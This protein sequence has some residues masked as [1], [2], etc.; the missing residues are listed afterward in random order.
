MKKRI[1]GAIALVGLVGAS[2][3]SCDSGKVVGGFDVP[4]TFDTDAKITVTFW[5][6]MGDNLQ[7]V[8]KEAIAGFN[9]YYPNVT[10]ESTQIGSY[11]DVKSQVVTEMSTG[12]FPSMA[13]CYDDHVAA[14][15][16]AEITVPLNNLMSNAKYGFGGSEV[17]YAIK[18]SDIVEGF[19]TKT[20]TF[21]DGNI[22]TVPFLRSTEVLYYNETFFNEHNLTVPA[23]WEDLWTVCAKIKELDPNSTPLGYDSEANFF[24]TLCQAYGYD[25]TTANSD[26][27]E[28]HFLFN[29]DKTNAMVSQ[30]RDY[31]E[32]GYFTT[33]KLFGAYTSGLFTTTDTN[34]CY[35]C[36]GSS[37]GASYQFPKDNLFTPGIA[38]LPKATNG[39]SAAI[40]QGPSLVFFNK[41]DSQ[42]VLAAW[43]FSQ[44]LLTA[45]I[46]AQ[47]ALTS[48]YM[49]V[50]TPATEVKAYQDTLAKAGNDS[51][52]NFAT[53]SIKTALA[54]K[55]SY[56]TSDVFVGSSDARDQVGA[57][58]PAILGDKTITADNKAAKIKA[59]FDAAIKQCVYLAS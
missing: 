45:D 23:T 11:D 29:N 9:K 53:L 20:D 55:D 42:E 10:I 59:H 56:F 18:E 57:L 26:T 37:A 52:N 12:N 35:M 4:E 27:V 50:T 28:G 58:I 2:L 3:T 32:K 41:G 51:K 1:L 5:N 14:Y 54:Q 13:Y 17:K 22:Y 31:Y 33:Q 30:L 7:T 38:Q 46:Q 43:L 6:T 49:P 16:E 48:G 40:S 36:I 34:K 47:F 15:N 19:R 25:Y 44:Y 39:K 21:G 24:I 8:L